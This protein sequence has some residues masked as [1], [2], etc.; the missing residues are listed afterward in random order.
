M[1]HS[2]NIVLL[3]LV[4]ICI[5]SQDTYRFRT[6]SPKGG[7]YYDGVQD[8]IQDDDGF[9]WISLENDLQRFDGYEYKKYSSHFQ[10]TD[11]PTT[12]LFH[13]MYKDIRGCL[14]VSTSNGLF[15]YH[16]QSD[17]FQQITEGNIAAI[18]IDTKDNIWY[19]SKGTL[20]RIKKAG[21]KPEP[22]LYNQMPMNNIGYIAKGESGMYFASYYNRIYYS[23]YENPGEVT[24]FH[25]LPSDHSIAGIRQ[26]DGYLWILT[27]KHGVL[28]MNILSR[29]I[30]EQLLFRDKNENTPLHTFYVDKNGKIWI[31]TQ[32]GLYIVNPV[33]KEHR[34]YLHSKSD[35]FSLPNNSVWV[36]AGD[37]YKNIWI[38]TY[39][40][41]LCYVNLDENTGFRTYTP[42]ESSLNHNLVSSFAEDGNSL[43]I[44]TEG[45]GLNC[46][47]KNTGMFTSYQHMEN[48]NSL[49]Y[50]N[51]KSIAFDSEKKL[52][53]AMYR[54]GLD[55]FDTKT[56]KFSHFLNNPGDKESLYSNDLRKIVL[57]GD[58]ALWIAYQANRS[59]ISYLSFKSG[60]F[61]HYPFDKNA[62]ILDMQKD[63]DG[64]LWI[65]THERFYR[66]NIKTR[67]VEN[68]SSKEQE[69]LNAQ[70]FCMDAEN[71]VWIGTVGRGLV[72]YDTSASRFISFRDILNFN[73]SA[74]YSM[75]SDNSG[76]L[77][78][79]TDNG[80]F[81]YNPGDNSYHRFDESDGLQ[82][83][84]Y[85]PLASFKSR[86]GELYFGGTN[87]FT[88]IN[89]QNIKF[90]SLIPEVIISDF[91]IDN[92][93]VTSGSDILN[94]EII[95]NHNQANFGFRFSSD[96]YLSPHKN[97]FRYRLRGYDDRWITVDASSRTVMYSKVPAGTYYFE[98]SAANN[99]GIWNNTPTVIKIERR[100][101][102]WVSWPAY[103]LYT[104]LVLSVLG[105]ILHYYKDKRKL[106]MQ[107]YL[108]NLDRLKKEEIHQSQLRFFTNISHDFRTPLSLILA[109][110][111]NLK[112]EGLKEYYY[113]ILHNNAQRLLNLV[114]EL[115]D[116]RTV[117]NGK[118]QLQVQHLNINR[119][120]T[121][122]SSD[123]RDYAQKRH[124]RF[125]IKCD[126]R[127]P[128]TLCADKQI[129]E[130]VVMNLLNNAFKYTKDG[131]EIVIETYSHYSEF[132]SKYK[133]SHTILEN[134][135]PEKAFLL[136]V[137]D[138]GVGISGNSI[139]TVFERFYKVNTAN[140][141]EHLGTGIGLALVK[142]LI[143]LHKGTISIFSERDKGTDIVV[144]LPAD[145]S[146]YDESEFDDTGKKED[147]SISRELLPKSNSGNP[148]SMEDIFLR[149]KKRILIVEDNADL[150]ILL[151][152]FLS[153]HYEII[154]AADGVEASCILE[155]TDVD[156]IL[157]DIMM[158]LKNGVELLREVKEDINTSHI[159]FILLTA[160]TGLESKIEGAGSG[161]DIYFEKP[162]D[163]NLLLL[164]IQNIFKRQQNLR[165]YYA[166]NY[167]VDSAELSAN[168]QDN[169]FLKR[170]IETIEVNLNQ[171]NIDVNYIASELSMSRSKL[172]SKVKTLTDK[173][174]VEFILNYR[175]RKAARLIIEQDMSILQVMDK[176]GI[177]SQS[178]FSKA[179][180]IEFGETPA[181]F[182]AKHK[183][184][185]NL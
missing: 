140:L 79:G 37:R 166:K 102:P 61:T 169:I 78:L 157:S 116:F 1:K 185:T 123:F 62:Y 12:C 19:I 47:D 95:L 81:R 170:L 8:I 111:D 82:G 114:N 3:L 72:K 89:P 54:G 168:E 80:L 26:I 125:E 52:W 60:K 38:G 172:Y 180:K 66:M 16:K 179:F 30:E 43:W 45:G 35:K 75:C 97:M 59:L 144:Y 36:I 2:L 14:Y 29:E 110:V 23:S 181:A 112:Q 113:R 141:N 124:I 67:I 171:P 99:D 121:D 71:N 106:K 163:L 139:G 51:V 158:P 55:C 174:I 128:E 152:N 7:F 160:K 126:P 119:L 104:V 25:L 92:V 100:P 118:M 33:T 149:N 83:Q 20:C 17:S 156:L 21:D 131:G 103:L 40:G 64:N 164:S 85:Y 146:V 42:F 159:P 175:L 58:S 4:S 153:Q 154:S 69:T 46:L 34:L 76:Y 28:K 105:I 133:Y 96:N 49:S 93:P 127:I 117:E 22:V 9:M 150:K 94:N 101:A 74:I 44:G 147:E 6:L 132:S 63:N 27:K 151:S 120:V 65:I 142:S 32:K 31:G 143:L 161:A 109:S 18:S 177:K 15:K 148:D 13:N 138:T 162:V 88:A 53:I 48:S 50:N 56:K 68:I 173:S 145:E 107:L 178:Y 155:D 87:G 90:N 41:G 77:W 115:M 136:V 183:R 129:V 137:R 91:Y 70:S 108:D 122:L 165:E 176:V 10:N 24:L 182:A 73:V 84:V 98:I 135:V 184:K 39:A 167:Y 57:E 5:Y 134:P 11:I 86:T 130:K